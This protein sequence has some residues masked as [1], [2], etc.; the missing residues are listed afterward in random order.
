MEAVHSIASVLVVDYLRDIGCD[1]AAK[2]LESEQE[3]AAAKGLHTLGEKQG[4]METQSAVESMRSL[5]CSMKARSI[6]GDRS[7][8]P[9]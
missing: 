6:P 5:L 7:T 4:H 8:G 9:Q 2:M 3:Q 1:E